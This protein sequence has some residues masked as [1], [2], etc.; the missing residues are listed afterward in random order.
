MRQ[1]KNIFNTRSSKRY[2]AYRTLPLWTLPLL[3]F[4]GLVFAKP[5]NGVEN[6]TGNPNPGHASTTKPG[7]LLPVKDLQPIIATLEAQIQQHLQKKQI[8]GCAIAIV[9]HNQIVHL[10][11]YGVRTMGRKEKVD[12]DTVFQL[13]SVSKPIAATLAS[14]LE[15]KGMLRLDD[16][17]N[18]YLPN[19]SLNS[20]QPPSSLK[21]KHLLSHSTGVPR[22]G[23]NQ[24]IETHKP[25]QQIIKSLKNTPV[26]APVGRQYDYHNAMYSVISEVTR[27]ATQLTFPEALRQ[28]L[29]LPLKMTRTSATYEALLSNENRASPHTRTRRG[30]TPCSTYS[31]GY[32]NAAPAGGINSSV[33]DMAIFLKAQMGG[34]PQVLDHRAIMRMQIPQVTTKSMLH[35]SVGPRNLIKNPRYGLGWRLIDFAD[36]RMVYHSGWVKGFTNFIAFAPD[37]SVGIV[38]LHNA[39]GGSKF[40]SR[41]GVKFFELF[42]DVPQMKSRKEIVMPLRCIPNKKPILSTRAHRHPPITRKSPFIKKSAGK[43]KKLS[44]LRKKAA[45]KVA[46]KN[47]AKA[48]V[49]TK[50]LPKS[51]MKAEVIRRN[52]S[53]AV[54]HP[55]KKLTT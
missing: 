41:I 44:A 55:K 10:K 51:K 20:V 30:L 14:V 32:Y 37:Q 39:E 1:R 33:R 29:L 48:N 18:Y 23:F 36:Q 45:V 16:P 15:N 8:A 12:I 9:Y 54:I 17:V 24:L 47:T 25:F 3:I 53:K 46:G 19:F 31:N 49:K 50:I 28:N 13:G 34:Y 11:G 5:A 7:S 2:R 38:V 43:N 22:A 40:P 4:C 26:R 42:Y 35:C 21:I 6:G 52:V 27:S